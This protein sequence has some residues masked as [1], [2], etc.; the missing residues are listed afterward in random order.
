MGSGNRAFHTSDVCEPNDDGIAVMI[1]AIAPGGERLR[2][3]VEGCP[4][5]ALSLLEQETT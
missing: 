2:M 3:A 4:T 5:G 1:L